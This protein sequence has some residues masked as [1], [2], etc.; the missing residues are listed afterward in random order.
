MEA[1]PENLGN[2]MSEHICHQNIGILPLT[3][4]HGTRDIADD[5]EVRIEDF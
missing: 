1:N 3:H 4:V 5:V 2:V